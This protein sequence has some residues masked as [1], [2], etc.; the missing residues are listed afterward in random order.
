MSLTAFA[1]LAISSTVLMTSCQKKDAEI[2]KRNEVSKEIKITS[3]GLNKE[4]EGVYGLNGLFR[5]QF[6]HPSDCDW[7]PHAICHIEIKAGAW[8]PLTNIPI[9]F[10]DIG[11]V[12][13]VRLEFES[14][15]VSPTCEVTYNMPLPAFVANYFGH[16]NI[17][18][19]PG[20]YT[21]VVDP[22]HPHGFIDLN[23]VY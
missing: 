23:V 6:D 17:A 15:W 4:M 2:K 19:L 7:H 12:D 10:S 18:A 5:G 22:L 1:F 21:I 14:N 3:N 9:S 13:K 8:D 16:Q 20:V 11:E